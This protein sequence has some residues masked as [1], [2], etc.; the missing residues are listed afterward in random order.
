MKEKIVDVNVY[1]VNK[2]DDK[3]VS[4]IV[5]G[6]QQVSGIINASVNAKTN[7]LLDVKYDA[8]Q[9]AG[10]HIIRHMSNN[11]CRGALVGF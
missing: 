5:E 10:S 9:I 8:N 2:I 3:A 11:D 4:K 7:R 1:I 6:M